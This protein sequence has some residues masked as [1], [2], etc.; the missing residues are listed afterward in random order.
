MSVFDQ[1][2]ELWREYDQEQEEEKEEDGKGRIS[3]YTGWVH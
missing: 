3:N 2:H 1:E